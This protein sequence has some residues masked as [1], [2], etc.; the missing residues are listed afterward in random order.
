MHAQALTSQYDCISAGPDWI[1]ATAKGGYASSDFEHLAD[2]EF[3]KERSSGGNVSAASR[4]G[5]VGHKCEGL[6]KGTRPDGA[7]IITSGPR[8]CPLAQELI[9]KATNVSR[10]D[11]QVTLWT[12]GE[13]PHLGLQGY[14]TVKRLKGANGKPGNLTLITG[15][16]TGETFYVNKRVSDS[17]GRCYDKATESKLG[18]E[19]TVWRYECE[20][21]RAVAKAY[22][23][24]LKSAENIRTFCIDH[25]LR[26]WSK[27]G[28]QIPLDSKTAS[29]LSNVDV[30]RPNRHFLEWIRTNIAPGIAKSIRSEGLPVVLEALGLSS[31]VQ[32]KT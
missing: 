27:K 9:T 14:E 12:G 25:V 8:V 4:L 29:S 18:L 17:Y 23:D 31:V 3:Q 16:P 10:L 21:K 6:F 2:E 7:L 5:Y 1:T 11:I 28:V 32:L 15:W 30:T 24:R 13:Q 26:W 22:A 20:F 19:R